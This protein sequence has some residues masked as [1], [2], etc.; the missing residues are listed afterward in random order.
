[1][2]SIIPGVWFKREKC[3]HFEL[4]A[5]ERFCPNYAINNYNKTK[6]CDYSIIMVY[7]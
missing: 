2:N 7:N 4:V 1:M 3:S 5:L 6:D